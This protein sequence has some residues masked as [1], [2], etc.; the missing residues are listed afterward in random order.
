ILPADASNSRDAKAAEQVTVAYSNGILRIEA[1]TGP[2]HAEPAPEPS[3]LRHRDTS[4]LRHSADHDI[5][6]DPT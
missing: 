1:P 2:A 6:H 5:R 4:S 3:A